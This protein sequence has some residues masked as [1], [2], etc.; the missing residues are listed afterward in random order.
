M[1]VNN[2]ENSFL[3]SN[4]ENTLFYNHYCVIP[5]GTFIQN[6]YLNRVLFYCQANLCLTTC[7]GQA[8]LLYKKFVLTLYTHIVYIYKP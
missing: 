5:H 2:Y 8:K 3:Y 4:W 1:F 7:G 6:K